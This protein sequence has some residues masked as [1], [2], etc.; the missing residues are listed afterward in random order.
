MP[1]PAFRARALSPR[2]DRPSGHCASP[3]GPLGSPLGSSGPHARALQSFSSDRSVK[4]P[5]FAFPALQPGDAQTSFGKANKN[6]KH[7]SQFI[8]SSSE[9]ARSVRTDSRWYEPSGSFC[10]ESLADEP[11]GCRKVAGRKS[12]TK[13]HESDMT[14]RP[15]LV[16]GGA[17]FPM[18]QVAQLSDAS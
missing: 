3:P 2:R 12:R 1:D 11:D 13:I 8:R 15:L 18:L 7:G 5:T 4:T 17:C 6:G 9:W 10:R 16:P 14:T